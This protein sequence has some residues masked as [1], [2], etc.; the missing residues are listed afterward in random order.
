MKK[1]YKLIAVLGIAAIGLLIGKQATAQTTDSKIPFQGS[2][3]DQGTPVNG[4]NEMVFSITAA[5]WTETHQVQVINGLYT[6]VLGSVT[7][8]PANLF[9]GVDS[10]QLAITVEGTSMGSVAIYA[11]FKG[12]L[13][14]DP[15][16]DF[17]ITNPS[18]DLRA[19]LNYFEPNDAGSLVLYGANDSTKVILGSTSGGYGGFLGL[20]DSTRNIGVNIRTSNKG[21]GNLYTYNNTHQNVGWFGGYGNSGFSQI[22][23]YDDLGN[24]QGAIL[25]GFWDG[26]PAYV[27]EDENERQGVT[28]SMETGGAA[29]RSGLVMTWGPTTPNIEIRGKGWDDNELPIIQMFGQHTDGASWYKTNAIMEV[30]S[31]GTS[32]WGTLTLQ[33][34]EEGAGRHESTVTLDGVDGSLTLRSPDGSQEFRIDPTGIAGAGQVDEYV[35][36]TNGYSNWR[37]GYLDGFTNYGARLD[38]NG[39]LDGSD[40]LLPGG[41][42]IGNKYWD[43]T[44]SQNGYLHINAPT[45]TKASLEANADGT[46]EWATLQLDNTNGE[47]TTVEPGFIQVNSAAGRAAR[48]RSDG[49]G[50]GALY[51]YNNSGSNTGFY[52]NIA[53]QGGF[54]QLVGRDGSNN[55]TGAVLN[56]F[57]NGTGHASLWMEDVNAQMGANMLI[58]DDGTDNWGKIV[59][60][61]NANAGGSSNNT[62]EIH[63]GESRITLRSVDGSD[64]SGL[65]PKT[66]EGNNGDRR[67][68]L[69]LFG[70][71]DGLT[72]G[73]TQRAFLEVNNDGS[74]SYGVLGLKNYTDDGGG[75]GLVSIFLNGE[76]GNI[77][78]SS[79]DA[80]HFNMNDP[81]S[82]LTLW[83]NGDGIFMERIFDGVNP[84]GGH[85]NVAGTGFVDIDGT[86]GNVDISGAYLN[87]SDRR[88]K[89]NISTLDNALDNTMK[90]R[91]VSYNWKDKNKSQRNQIGVIAQEVEEVYPEFVHTNEKGYKA[92][93]YAQMTAVLIEAVKELNAKV[94]ALEGENAELKAELTKVDLLEHQLNRFEEMLTGSK[95]NTPRSSLSASK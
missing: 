15:G 93:N 5:S 35:I 70:T 42:S 67:G 68:Y 71:D 61:K 86:T 39:G 19:D 80:S 75:N 24:S 4:T 27:M 56:G 89:K 92:V 79:M 47:A 65:G 77:S 62:V 40:N 55:A 45:G 36:G 52:G 18:G 41:G 49:S 17:H 50:E 37:S 43:A 6:V 78:S 95:G 3:Y 46:N 87:T 23:G 30:S 84:Q 63:G 9:T 7:P 83:N 2:L 58:E 22:V 81:N 51:T 66:W 21:L 12:E 91:G 1:T 82:T 32:N 85:I 48:L 26:Y 54:S 31:D 14:P 28:M 57:W 44:Y 8:L 59:L 29:D 34:S 33:N 74:G 53:G 76:S 13:A 20:Y 73:D 38:F 72:N 69:H 11:P 10:Q 88:F 60:N 94:E 16:A 90:L 64:V 25:S